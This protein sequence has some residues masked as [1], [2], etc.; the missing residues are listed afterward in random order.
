MSRLQIQYNMVICCIFRNN[1][2]L[3]FVKMKLIFCL[4]QLF[5]LANKNL[6]CIKKIQSANMVMKVGLYQVPASITYVRLLTLLAR[7]ISVG[8]LSTGIIKKKKEN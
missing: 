4:H 1:F 6:D 7:Y 3:S 8:C 5:P 2:V